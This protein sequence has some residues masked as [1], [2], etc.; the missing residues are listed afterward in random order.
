LFVIGVAPRDS[1]HKGL[2]KFVI[3]VLRMRM[4]IIT[5]T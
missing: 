2:L 1:S 4:I 3:L 5:I